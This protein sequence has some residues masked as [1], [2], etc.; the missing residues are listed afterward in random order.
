MVEMR[1]LG[2]MQGRLVPP[3]GGKI[4][5]FPHDRWREEFA[6]AASLKL[7]FIEWIYDSPSKDTNPICKDCGTEKVLELI[8]ES[9]VKVESICADYFMDR[10]LGLE[11]NHETGVEK[12][13]WLIRTVRA[14]NG[15]RIV[16]PFVKYLTDDLRKEISV[17]AMSINKVIAEAERCNVELHL[18]TVLEPGIFRELLDMLPHPL[19]K[20]NYDTGNSTQFEFNFDEEFAL[21]GDRIGSI[22]IKD[23]R[24][25]V[26]TVPL[27]EGDT[28]FIKIFK[29]LNAD[30]KLLPYLFQAAR[31]E[32]NSEVK[33]IREYLGFVNGIIEKIN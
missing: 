31:G 8:S 5:E 26:G 27:G 28:D 17:F 2:I 23:G 20:V 22:H 29:A 32:N 30:S 9:G 10:S 25:G 1:S 33:L 21:Y 14:L 19:V 7:D 11:E 13:E 24:R 4:Q 15:D 3:V 12:L 6:K 16:I 18:E